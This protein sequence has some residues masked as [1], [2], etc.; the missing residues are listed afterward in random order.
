LDDPIVTK[1][2]THTHMLTR[3]M[4]KGENEAAISASLPE[5]DVRDISR[6]KCRD[7]EFKKIPELGIYE[8]EGVMLDLGFD[9]NILSKKSWELMGKP[10]LV[11]SP[12]QLSLAS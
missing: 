10:K 9:V 8:M 1:K 5:M 4:E 6:W 2:L 3:C 11:W 7:K 12:I